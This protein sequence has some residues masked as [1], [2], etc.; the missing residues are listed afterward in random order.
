MLY[1]IAS[2]VTGER[3]MGRLNEYDLP[4]GICW[5]GSLVLLTD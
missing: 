3:L 1:S 2:N 5:D 4:G